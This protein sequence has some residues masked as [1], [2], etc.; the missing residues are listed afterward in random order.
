MKREIE[1]VINT[2]L[3]QAKTFRGLA[4]I[5]DKDPRMKVET[6]V[7]HGLAEACH[8]LVNLV[9]LEVELSS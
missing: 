9:R 5:L 6:T 1:Q 7:C 2:L 8:G 4:K 3:D